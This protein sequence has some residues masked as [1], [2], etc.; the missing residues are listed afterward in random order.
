MK[1]SKTTIIMVLL[2]FMGLLI[3]LYPSLSDFYNQKVQSKSIVDYEAVLKTLD[4]DK[5]EEIFNEADKYN[6][7]L[8]KLSNQFLNYHN[9]QSFYALLHFSL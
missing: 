5:Y 7:N 6:N 2:F 8:A 9:L 1:R 3:L 4:K